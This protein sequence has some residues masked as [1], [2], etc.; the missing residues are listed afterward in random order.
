MVRM[1][2]RPPVRVADRRPI[3]VD[4]VVAVQV[5][6]DAVAT[7]VRTRPAP[8]AGDG[9]NAGAERHPAGQRRTEIVAG[10]RQMDRWMGWIGPRAIDEGWIVERHMDHR[11]LSRLDKDGRTVGPDDLLLSALQLTR[12]SRLL[13]E[14]L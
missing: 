12:G 11:R 3:Y 8:Q 4:R 10:R 7:P 14:A 2:A 1:A 5:H 6:G 13:A 9:R